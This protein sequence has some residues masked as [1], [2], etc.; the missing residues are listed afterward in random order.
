MDAAEFR[1]IYSE[2]RTIAVVGAS[3]DPDKA[4][5]EIPRYLQTQGYRILPVT[6]REGQ[7]FGEWTYPSLRDIGVPIDAVNVFRPPEEAEGIARDAVAVGAKVLW[8]QQGTESAEAVAIA[9]EAGLNVVW[10]R[11]M[12]TVH[13]QL[14]LGPGPW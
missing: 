6:P 5:H 1:R 14:G 10:G 2:T 4:G 3:T 12:G 9:E 7:I 8:Y 13:G 11:C